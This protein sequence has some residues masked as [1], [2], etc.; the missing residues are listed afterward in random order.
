MRIVNLTQHT[1]TAAQREEGVFEP[2]NKGKIK[3]LLN[4][5]S[6]AVA[7]AFT[8]ERAENLAACAWGEGAEAAMIGGAP[9][10]MGSLAVALRMRGIRPLFAFSE[11]VSS[12][13]TQ[14]DGT[15]KKVSVFEHKGFIEG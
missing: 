9:Y 13:V 7:Q 5:E 14:S 3:E 1:A 8:R 2:S 12:E 6:C 15:V 4:F 10:L 11:R